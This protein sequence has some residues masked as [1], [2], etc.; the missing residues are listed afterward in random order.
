MSRRKSFLR[1]KVC[2]LRLYWRLFSLY[3]RSRAVQVFFLCDNIH[4]TTYSRG[5]EMFQL[6]T[7]IVKRNRG[8]FTR[9]LYICIKQFLDKKSNENVS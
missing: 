7:K 8:T 3:D 1:R 4:F 2:V 9:T 5:Y 6:K